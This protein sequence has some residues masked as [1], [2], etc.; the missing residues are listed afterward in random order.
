MG[1]SE[2]QGMSFFYYKKIVI[3]TLSWMGKKVNASLEPAPKIIPVAESLFQTRSSTVLI[4]TWLGG[5]FG[6]NIAF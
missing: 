2:K 5:F 1:T 6:E 4:T 3:L